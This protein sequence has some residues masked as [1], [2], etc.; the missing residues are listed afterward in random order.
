MEEKLE[1]GININETFDSLYKLGYFLVDL[2]SICNFSE[3]LCKQNIEDTKKKKYSY[4]ITSRYLNKDSLDNIKL[5]SFK[6]GSFFSLIVA[7]LIVGVVLLILKMYINQEKNN[8]KIEITINN[9]TINNIVINNF[10][11][12]QTLENNFDHIFKELSDKKLVNHNFSIYN[13]EGKKI[14]LHNM[15]RIKGQLVD[16]KW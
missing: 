10:N 6:Q 3:K 16:N 2:N 1:I 9:P 13:N 7:P 4:G 5:L 15:K 11:Q 8:E 12:Q 14:L